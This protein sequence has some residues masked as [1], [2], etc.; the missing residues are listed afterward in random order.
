ME[1]AEE[2]YQKVVLLAPNHHEARRTLSNILHKL[3]RAGEALDTLTQGTVH[4]I[5]NS[6]VEVH[7]KFHFRHFSK[8]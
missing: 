2:A 3:G 8:L 6:L 7:N 5:V 1:E 4:S